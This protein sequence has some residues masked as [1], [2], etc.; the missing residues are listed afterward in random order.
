M[1][2]EGEHVN[3]GR[4]CQQ[5]ES[6]STEGEHVNR[7]RACQQKESMSTDGVTL[8]VSVPPSRCS[9]CPHLV[10]YRAPDKRFSHTLTVSTDGLGQPVSFPAHRQP[11]SRNFMYHSRIVLSVGGSVCYT[12]RNLRC[13]VKI[14]SVLANS[15]T[16][17]TF[18]FP[19]HAMFR[20]DCTLKVKPA[21]TLWRLVHKKTWRGSLPIDIFLSAV[22]VVVIVQPSSEF[23]EGLNESPRIVFHSQSSKPPSP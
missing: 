16:Q 1:S 6:M 14:D 19:V 7:R 13:T 4:A 10:T 5:K 2:T 15:R 23:P 18:L 12:V 3:R 8:Q 17:N 20:Y 21:S 22:S 9:I 11:L